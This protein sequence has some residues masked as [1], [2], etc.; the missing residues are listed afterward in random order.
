[1]QLALDISGK[2]NAKPDTPEISLIPGLNTFCVKNFGQYNVKFV[3]CHSYDSKEL[4]HSINIADHVPITVNAI[5][6][7]TGIRI[8]SPIPATYRLLVESK[9]KAD[10]VNLVAESAKVDGNFAYRY[11]FDLKPEERVVLTPHSDVMLFNPERTDIVGA[12]DCV[13]VSLVLHSLIFL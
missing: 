9:E 1:M 13:D 12:H 5:K 7:R 8:L 10:T 3:G 11:D 6:H 2:A 4:P